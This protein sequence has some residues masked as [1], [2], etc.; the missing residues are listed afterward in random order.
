[1]KASE[2]IQAALDN[3]YRITSHDYEKEMFMCHA[4]YRLIQ[5]RDCVYYIQA[6]DIAEPV[7]KLFMP[8]INVVDTDC[9]TQMLRNTNKRYNYLANRYGD[10]TPA[11]I[12]VR[13]EFWK[14]LI[15]DLEL[16]GL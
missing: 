14:D 1:M 8:L 5:R 16:K 9:L 6:V 15:H 2:V 13:I 10:M 7:I 4:I 11:C 12:K 3:H